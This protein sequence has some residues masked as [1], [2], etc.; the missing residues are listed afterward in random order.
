MTIREYDPLTRRPV[1]Y[2]NVFSIRRLYD[3]FINLNCGD[4]RGGGTA[5]RQSVL[6]TGRQRRWAIGGRC[7]GI[8]TRIFPIT[9][10][11]TGCL[12]HR[13]SQR[14]FYSRWPRVF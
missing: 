10:R 8:A 11:E 2:R 6:E 14:I 1:A 7:I 4:D 12:W 3:C 9:R 5:A 13:R